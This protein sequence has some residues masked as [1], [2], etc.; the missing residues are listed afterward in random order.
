MRKILLIFIIG[1]SM[2]LAQENK[3]P[4]VKISEILIDCQYLEEYKSILQEES[5]QSVK[6][7]SGVLI[8]YAMQHEENP[9]KFSIMEVYKDKQSYDSHIA[10]PHFQRYKQGTL[11]M[12]KELKFIPGKALNP[13]MFLDKNL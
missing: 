3:E 8:L 2:V 10:S 7:E 5:K 11:H 6:S 13:Q 1:V 9:C 4:L 12:V